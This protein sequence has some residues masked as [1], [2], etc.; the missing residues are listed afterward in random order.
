MNNEDRLAKMMTSSFL[1]HKTLLQFFK[2]Q[3]N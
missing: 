2:V 3:M 1:M